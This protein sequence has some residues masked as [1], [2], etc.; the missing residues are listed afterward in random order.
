MSWV[1]LLIGSGIDPGGVRRLECLALTTF[2]YECHLIATLPHWF[3]LLVHPGHLWWCLLS[4][5]NEVEV[6]SRIFSSL[7]FIF[8]PQ[9]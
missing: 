1:A 8:S 6:S 3:L 2:E 4:R 9:Y 7:Y 5:G